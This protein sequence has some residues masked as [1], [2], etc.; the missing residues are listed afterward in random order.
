M[1]CQLWTIYKVFNSDSWL[2]R[3]PEGVC[4]FL[5]VDVAAC[6]WARDD[7]WQRWNIA[8]AFSYLIQ[9]HRCNQKYNGTL[10]LYTVLKT[11]SKNRICCYNLLYGKLL[12]TTVTARW[13]QGVWQEGMCVYT[14]IKEILTCTLA[15]YLAIWTHSCNFLGGLDSGENL[16]AI[17]HH[18]DSVP[19]T[20]RSQCI[21]PI[22]YT[23]AAYGSSL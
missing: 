2:E 23:C 9:L 7:K 10:Q 19:L 21:S 14:T 18:C 16:D 8:I 5:V 11:R 20:T 22:H 3:V 1:S 4:L 12:A 15:K 6:L 13:N 17:L